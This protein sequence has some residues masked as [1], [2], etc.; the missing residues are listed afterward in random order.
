MYKNRLRKKIWSKKRY[1]D[2]AG[3]GSLDIKHYGM[4]LLK[5]LALNSKSILDLGCGEGTRLY[6]LASNNQK[7]V[8]IDISKK[9]ITIAQ[10]KYPHLN[11]VQG[12]LE[13]LPCKDNIFDLVYSAFVLEHVDKPEEVINESIRVT[14]NGGSLVFIAPN[15]GSP[16]RSSPVFVGSRILKLIKGFLKDYFS[17]FRKENRLIWNKVKP[18]TKKYFQDSDTTVEPYVRSLIDYLKERRLTI[19][20]WST[21]WEEEFTNSKLVQ[22]FFRRLGEI[23]MFPFNFWGP[24]L[25]VCA[26]KR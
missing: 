26:K 14:K 7:A 6:Y 1:Y 9:A 22:R 16:N 19:S 11:F 5:R 21:A 10:E 3:H 12:N 24:H 17:L 2:L 25:I 23:G 18:T 4:K 15:Y 8:G 20:V 13:S